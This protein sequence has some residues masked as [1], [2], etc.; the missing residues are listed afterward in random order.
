MKKDPNIFL[1]HILESIEH[2]E[3]YS[4][5]KNKK[6]FKQDSLLQD[7][8]IRRLEIIGEAVKHLPKTFSKKYS[9]VPW[10]EIAGTRDKLIH[11]YF[12]VDLDLTYDVVKNH[13]PSLKKQIEDILEELSK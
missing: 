2:I 13:L 1:Q 7:A 12:G 4:E 6:L 8:I 11:H 10:S 9:S 5:G 3:E